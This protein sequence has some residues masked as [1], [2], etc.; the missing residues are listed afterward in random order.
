MRKNVDLN[1]E[2]TKRHT[3]FI[4]PGS[5]W[6]NDFNESFNGKLRD[7]LLKAEILYIPKDAKTIV[8]E[9]GVSTTATNGPTAHW[10]NCH[11][12]LRSLHQDHH[13]ALLYIPHLVRHNEK[14]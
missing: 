2:E 9:C 12:R 14:C 11:R 7:E 6:E 10:A 1:H 5:P 13:R 4:E 8:E 3:L